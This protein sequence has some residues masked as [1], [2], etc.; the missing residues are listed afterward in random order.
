M[1]Q[2]NPKLVMMRFDPRTGWVKPSEDHMEMY[3]DELQ[4]T[5]GLHQETPLFSTAQPAAPENLAVLGASIVEV[6][7]SLKLEDPRLEI[8]D[9]VNATIENIAP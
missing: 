1:S 3:A 2:Q 6:F 5:G 8:W 9:Q 4:K 7:N